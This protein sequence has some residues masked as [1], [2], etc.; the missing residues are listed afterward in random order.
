[1][2]SIKFGYMRYHFFQQSNIKTYQ[3]TIYITQGVSQQSKHWIC[4]QALLVFFSFPNQL[5]THNRAPQLIA[6]L[7]IEECQ[8]G[9]VSIADDNNDP[10][11]ALF[12]FISLHSRR[13]SR[14]SIA[15]GNFNDIRRDHMNVAR[16]KQFRKSTSNAFFLVRNQQRNHIRPD[17]WK[18][19]NSGCCQP[20][21]SVCHNVPI[22]QAPIF[23][24]F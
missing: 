10:V 24:G 5:P 1:M 3:V 23:E 2:T 22:K 17:F 21:S 9:A 14:Q 16:R 6:T 7:C 13:R 20:V 15:R 19:P 8:S 4:T 18:S 12:V 11:S